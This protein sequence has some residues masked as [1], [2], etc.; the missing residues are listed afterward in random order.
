MLIDLYIDD[1]GTAQFMASSHCTPGVKTLFQN[2]ER[3]DAEGNQKLFHDHVR[4]LAE[5]LVGRLFPILEGE[6]QRFV[7]PTIMGKYLSPQEARQMHGQ[8]SEAIQNLWKIYRVNIIQVTADVLEFV[9]SPKYWDEVLAT[10]ILPMIQDKLLRQQLRL[11]VDSDP[12]QFRPLLLRHAFAADADRP[13]LVAEL[14]SKL[15]PLVSPIPLDEGRFNKA[16]DELL[17]LIQAEQ[18]L[19]CEKLEPSLATPRGD[20]L[21]KKIRTY[22]SEKETPERQQRAKNK[23]L[24]NWQELIGKS[25]P[26][27]TFRKYAEPLLGRIEVRWKQKNKEQESTLKDL[28]DLELV[29]QV[30]AGKPADVDARWGDLTC[31]YIF[32]IAPV[33]K[34][35]LGMVGWDKVLK[36]K[37]SEAFTDVI[38]TYRKSP[39]RSLDALVDFTLSRLGKQ[40]G[41]GL[42]DAKI[43]KL[44]FAS[45]T[46]VQN[47][48][49]LLS[50]EV[51]RVAQLTHKLLVQQLSPQIAPLPTWLPGRKAIA[52]KGASMITGQDPSYLQKCIHELLRSVFQNP[53]IIMDR[54]DRVVTATKPH[55]DRAIETLQEGQ[56]KAAPKPQVAPTSLA[57]HAR[58]IIPVTS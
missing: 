9:T 20:F 25:I 50:Q 32:Q 56:P 40:D 51:E 26:E 44:L 18:A 43:K 54:L 11:T 8:V 13:A 12:R 19:L 30:I 3:H 34:S 57:P 15:Y 6:L 14:R 55:L 38:D 47:V 46:P 21:M 28:P 16:V 24:A 35:M 1:Y 48:P 33:L 31:N 49:A 37:I 5:E 27:E 45:Y 29:R 42:D 10:E 23:I 22:I 41:S 4:S 2:R 7:L 53:Y 36:L 52:K 17:T 58:Q 39:E